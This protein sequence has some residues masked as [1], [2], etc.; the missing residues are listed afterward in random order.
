[1]KNH[2]AYLYITYT[3]IHVC[4]YVYCMCIAYVVQIRCYSGLVD[5]KLTLAQHI[6]V[7]ADTLT[8]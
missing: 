7:E 4:I 5:V 3:D 1:M 8:V 2:P 6:L